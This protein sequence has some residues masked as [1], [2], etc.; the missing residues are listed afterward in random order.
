MPSRTKTL[1][2][3]IQ[4]VD[5][6]SQTL[7]YSD[8]TLQESFITNFP[9]PLLGKEDFPDGMNSNEI[10]PELKEKI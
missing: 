7:R 3:T 4:Q 6:S 1:H 2:M 9:T 5:K 10:T 8:V